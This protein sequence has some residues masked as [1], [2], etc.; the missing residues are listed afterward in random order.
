MPL[1]LSLK[2]NEKLVING[3]VIANG[4]K[5]TTLVVQNQAAILR[6]KEIL[7]AD[8]ADPFYRKMATQALEK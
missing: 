4:D 3:A 5:R 2:P 8:G 7:Q 6:E 1:K